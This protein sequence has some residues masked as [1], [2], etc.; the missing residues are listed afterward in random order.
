MRQFYIILPFC[1]RKGKRVS[2]LQSN[3]IEFVSKTIQIKTLTASSDRSN[4]GVRFSSRTLASID[5]TLSSSFTCP[6]WYGFKKAKTAK[7]WQSLAASARFSSDWVLVCSSSSIDCQTSSGVFHWL[8][9]TGAG[10]DWSSM[11]KFRLLAN[12]TKPS[13][14]SRSSADSASM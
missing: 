4:P 13:P 1:T 9:E 7:S 12:S 8:Q 10:I 3:R 11:G 2:I 6:M 14:W 5:P